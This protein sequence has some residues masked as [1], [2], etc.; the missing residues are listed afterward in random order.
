[1]DPL[2]LDQAT[3]KQRIEEANV[4]YRTGTSLMSDAEYDYLLS[5]VDDDSYRIKVGYEVERAKIALKVPMG[6]LNKVKTREEIL[7]WRKSKD[8]PPHTG[9]TLMPKFDG[10][11]LL[12]EI[13]NGRFKNAA[14]RGDGITGQDVT[15]HFRAT[16][17]GQVAMPA[18]FSGF[19][20]GEAILD[21]GTFERR[22]SSTFKNPRNMV[23]GLLSRKQ[24]SPE[25]G[26]LSFIA[27]GVRGRDFARKTEELQFCNDFVNR[28]F[29]Y[30]IRLHSQPL[31]TLSNDML[32]AWFKDETRFQCD[33]LVLFIEDTNLFTELGSETSSLNPAGARAW[34]PESDDQR[35]CRVDAVSWQVSKSGALKPV[36]QIDPVELGGVTISNVTGINARFMRDNRIAAGALVAIIRS[37]DVIPK[38]VSVALPAPVAELPSCCTAKGCGGSLAWNDNEVDLICQNPACPEKGR[39]EIEDFFKI[40]EVEEVGEG[41]VTQLWLAGYKSVASIL[42]LGVDEL[43]RLD[44]F[45]KRKA[46][47]VFSSIQA[48][49]QG[50]RLEKLQH[51]SNLFKGLGSRRLELLARFDSR[52]KKPS[53]DEVLAIDGFSDI[54]ADAY[55]AGFDPFWDWYATLPGI[56]LAAPK[57]AAPSDGPLKGKDFVFTGVRSAEMEA[58]IEAL[59][60]KIGSGV[61]GKTFAL[62]M[63]AKGSGSSKEKKAVELGV[64]IFELGELETFLDDYGPV[65]VAPFQPTLF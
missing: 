19:L 3:L 53:R 61:T 12:V 51:A 45:K 28:L 31:D 56:S 27:Y 23:A 57:A 9:L 38:I 39:A 18:D 54:T 50:V 34:K 63:K 14:T 62:V 29:D 46:E 2:K 22:Y 11:S 58:R 41:V 8:F 24:I 4:A 1:M 7:E 35:V 32:L 40:L 5:L 20:V 36:V 55:F 26:D 44:G 33:G 49:L 17:L 25:L 59:G 30:Q 43:A 52:D 21:L 10:L 65:S 60:G 6:S 13:E 15:E 16:R 42:A 47:K 48:K 37:G 64:R